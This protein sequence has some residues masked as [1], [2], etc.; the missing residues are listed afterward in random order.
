MRVFIGI[1]PEREA[2]TRLEEEASPLRRDFPQFKWVDPGNRHL[3]L[4]FLGEMSTA[5][6][7]KLCSRLKSSLPASTAIPL[8]I[9]GLGGFPDPSSPRV[10]WA[11]IRNS[12]ALTNLF[13]HLEEILESLGIPR[14]T[15]RFHPH[16]TL[17]RIRRGQP[18]PRRITERLR[19]ASG[20]IA[21]FRVKAVTV[22]KSVLLPEGPR[23]SILEEISLDA[24]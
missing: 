16:I 21:A 13:N 23:Y 1:R 6:A 19:S 17:A 22:F 8:E 15:R 24:T 4:R 10:I 5:D 12:P 7:E 3:T 9:D 20:Q 14:E 2:L 11:G 18:A